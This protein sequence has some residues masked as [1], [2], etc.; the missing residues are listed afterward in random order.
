MPPRPATG[1]RGTP[2]LPGL[3]LLSSAARELRKRSYPIGALGGPPRGPALAGV[4]EPMAST[5]Q[6]AAVWITGASSGLGRAM[7]LEF[8]RQGANVAVTSRRLDLLEEVAAEVRRLG[9]TALVVP[10]DC[11]DEAQVERAAASVAEGFGRIDVAIAN[12]GF[13]VAGKVENL[14]ADDWRRQL[15]INVVGC[16]VTARHAIPHLLRTRGRLALVGSVSALAYVPG[17]GA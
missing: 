8:A 16:A 14:S 7:A 15:D 13:S 3:G 17:A 5:F 9:R 11:T 2:R 1:L 4:G 10:A 12:A 6:D